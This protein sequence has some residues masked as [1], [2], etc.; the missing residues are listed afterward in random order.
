MSVR[1][2]LPHPHVLQ[3]KTTHG[4]TNT[5]IYNMVSLDL[6]RQTMRA[7]SFTGKMIPHHTITRTHTSCLAGRVC[8][9][10]W[11]CCP[12]LEAFLRT[13]TNLKDRTL[14]GSDFAQPKG[15]RSQ[16][17]GPHAAMCVCHLM[18]AQDNDR[19]RPRSVLLTF[20]LLWKGDSD[21]LRWLSILP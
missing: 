17:T 3:N 5:Y 13:H 8:G 21:H 7:I 9:S 16:L 11:S 15:K 19:L 14:Q 2:L 20:L 6:S 18:L 4:N 10:Q 1:L 12:V